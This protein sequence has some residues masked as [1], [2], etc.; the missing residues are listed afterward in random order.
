ML[1]L[2][3]LPHVIDLWRMSI[4]NI[5]SSTGPFILLNTSFFL[6]TSRATTLRPH[7]PVF[8]MLSSQ[9]CI[10]PI[11]DSHL[12]RHLSSRDSP[13]RGLCFC[14]HSS[15]KS[16]PGLLKIG[17]VW[18]SGKLWSSGTSSQSL[19]NTKLWGVEAEKY[20]ILLNLKP[21]PSL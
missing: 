4:S 11:N 6:F 10:I 16:S 3:H 14:R 1:N 20:L 19:H 21:P 12:C 13:D 8:L 9:Y 15:S 17:E 2:L 18:T 7:K 5:L